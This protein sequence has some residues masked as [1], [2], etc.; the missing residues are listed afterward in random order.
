[1]I[2]I[3]PNYS[4]TYLL[5]IFLA[6]VSFACYYRV[7]KGYEKKGIKSLFYFQRFFLIFSG[8]MLM[9][10]LPMLVMTE[11]DPVQQGAFYIMARPFLYVSLA[12]FIQVPFSISFPKYK[13]YAVGFNL[14]YGAVAWFTNFHF[15]T[16]NSI[17]ASSVPV[18][19]I[20]EVL[21]TRM[22]VVG[23]IGPMIGI[24]VILNWIVF[25]LIYF[26]YQA[27]KAEGT[28]RLKFGLMA[29]ALGIMTVGGPMHDNATTAMEFLIADG[30][31]LLGLIVLFA[32]I[33]VKKI[34]Q[35]RNAT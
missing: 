1:M 24:I 7:K 25:G 27:F 35:G 33:Y 16:L 15:W 4:L 34:F 8:F 26:G 30:L 21:I 13:K 17:E 14:V 29:I 12:Y 23:P 6:L 31:I 18:G 9:N 20:E 28:T 32:G 2:Q 19:F 5:H 3:L 11:L 10:G 22:D